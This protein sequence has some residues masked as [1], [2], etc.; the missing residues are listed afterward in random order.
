MAIPS[1]AEPLIMA[2][3]PE[4]ADTVYLGWWGR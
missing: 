3:D 4:D 2:I 1:G